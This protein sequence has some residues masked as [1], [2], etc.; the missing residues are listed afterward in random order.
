M[1]FQEVRRPSIQVGLLTAIACGAGFPCST[2]HASVLFADRVGVDRY[3]RLSAVRSRL[4][5]DWLFSPAAFGSAA[6]DPGAALLADFAADLARAGLAPDEL[7]HVRDHDVPAFL[8][9]LAAS[10]VWDDVDVVGFTATFQQ[11]VPSLALATLLKERFPHLVTVFGGANLDGEMGPELLRTNDCVD[12]AVIGEGDAAFPGLLG[13]LAAGTDP[14]A[15]PGVA[16][17][18]RPPRPAP[19]ADLD[20]LPVPDYAEYFAQAR[21]IGLVPE[22][23]PHDVVIPFESGRGC[24]WGAKHHCTF[25][26]LNGATMAWRAKS[27]D[28]VLAELAEQAR[29]YRSFSFEAVDN[30]LDPSYVETVLA[31]LAEQGTDYEIFYEVKAN[32]TRSDVRRLAAAGVR[33]V[34]PG[35]ESLSSRVLALMR[36]GVRASQNVNLLRWARYYGVEPSWNLLWGFAGETPEDY[37]EQAALVPHLAHLRPPEATGRIWLERFSPMFTDPQLRYRFRRPEA[38]YRYAYPERVDLERLAYFFEYELADA[39]PDETFA[40]LRSAVATWQEA[41]QRPDLPALTYR[42]SPGYLEIEDARW[43][44]TAGTYS[45]TGALAELYRASAERP[46]TAAAAGRAVAGALSLSTIELAWAEWE[47]QGLVFRDG[48]RTLALALPSTPWR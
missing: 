47:R 33:R 36:K 13:A 34:Q 46:V 15:V 8:A 2:L 4:V 7:A 42:S 45:Y 32:L 10:G 29:R 37:A 22:R 19:R 1:P 17:R 31:R 23:G 25:C 18:G 5:G 3:E 16:V 26:G 39:L 27:A 38:S 35:I 40:P 11:T 20:R 21:A 14:A 41:W 43:P 6:P 48:D 24:W 28:V 44:E 12:Y 9:D 30:I